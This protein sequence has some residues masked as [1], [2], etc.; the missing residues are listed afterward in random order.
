M[1]VF[2]HINT[3]RAF[4]SSRRDTNKVGLVPTMGAL[5]EGHLKLV[6]EALDNTDIV[7]TSIFV[8]PTQFNKK[9]DLDNYPSTLE[10]DLEK[11]Q[12]T[13]CHVA[14]VPTVD[15]MYPSKP[16]LSMKFGLIEDALEGEFR[17]GH[18]SGVGLVVSKL[19]NIVQPHE[20]FFGQKD[21]QQFFVIKKMVDQLNVP[22][23]LHRVPTMR[24]KEGLALS[25]RN[26]RLSETDLEE[27]LLLIR[28]LEDAKELLL[29]N[30]RIE[31][32][33]SEIERRFETAKLL[34]LEYFE[35]IE[36][37]NFQPISKIEEKSKTALC[38]AAHLNNVRLIDN[39]L[40]IS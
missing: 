1:E 36:T 28:S 35:I 8:N 22:I 20:A 33:K 25:S 15:E 7:V 24:S 21:L 13:G 5:H 32:V 10:S 37:D 12:M 18:F 19:F 38:I 34:E 11:L 4:L 31:D 6:N 2:H 39:L 14:F 29:A 16:E 30:Q 9:E 27:A 17:E 40:L 26:M 3:L 23:K